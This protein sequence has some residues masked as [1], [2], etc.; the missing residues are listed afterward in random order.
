MLITDLAECEFVDVLSRD[1]VRSV[2]AADADEPT[3]G[4]HLTGSFVVVSSRVRVMAQ[5]VDR[6]TGTVIRAV[7]SEG[8]EAKIF[9]IID[10]I[11]AQVRSGL[12]GVIAERLGR[13]VDLASADER[14][15]D[16]LFAS[17]DAN[18]AAE[19][20]E[21]LPAEE[22]SF[23]LSASDADGPAPDAPVRYL[24][25]SKASSYARKRETGLRTATKKAEA[26]KPEAGE[27]SPPEE[28]QMDLTV[29][30]NDEIVLSGGIAVANTVA[31]AKAVPLPGFLEASQEVI[32]DIA[33]Q[34][35]DVSLPPKVIAMKLRYQAQRMSEESEDTASLKKSLHLLELAE[36]VAPDLLD[37][38]VEI[39]RTRRRIDESGK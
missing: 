26:R 20:P 23:S 24:R 30:V 8:P 25:R 12:E 27:A 28:S 9:S 38:R 7:R 1:R 14:V 18:R 5:L 13:P 6:G 39:P 33:A 2:L 31:D 37:L 34:R 21:T 4:I 36:K 29:A 10:D 15:F 11:S 19:G 3:D 17:A 32:R 16:R 22:A 35:E